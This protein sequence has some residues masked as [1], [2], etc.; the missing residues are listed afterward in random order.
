MQVA[1][2]YLSAVRS[3][4]SLSAG[5]SAQQTLGHAAQQIGGQAAK[6]QRRSE[7]EKVFQQGID[8]AEGPAADQFLHV[9]D[10]SNNGWSGPSSQ[11]CMW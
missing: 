7:W 2:D 10:L 3:S 6:A 8:L 5:S 11:V 4:A 9:C 1:A